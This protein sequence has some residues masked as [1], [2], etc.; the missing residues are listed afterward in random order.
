MNWS[1]HDEINQIIEKLLNVHLEVFG[2]KMAG[3]YLYGSLIWGDFDIVS[4]DIDT[5]CVITS[6]VTSEVIECLRYMHEEIANESPQWRGRV[7]VNDIVDRF[8]DFEK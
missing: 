8:F 3:F 1:W 5:L 2:D 7:V 6:E 4:S